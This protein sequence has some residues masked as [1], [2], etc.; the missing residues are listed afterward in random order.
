MKKENI[1]D[2]NR[3]TAMSLWNEQFGKATKVKDFAEREIAKGAYNDRNSK[4]GWNV[5]HILPQS[6]G[7]K[8][9]KSNLI[10]CH[11]LTNDEKADKF[12]CFVAN[13]IKF[14]IVK[15]E[16]HY[17]IQR[18]DSKTKNVISKSSDLNFMDSAVGINYYNQH[19]GMQNK[20]VF[21]G[22][23]KIK[24]TN[25][26]SLALVDFV[27]ELLNDSSINI[28][29]K[30]KSFSEKN[31]DVD[32]S[33]RVFDVPT[34]ED[35]QELLDKCVMIYTYLGF[36]HLTTQSLRSYDMY[37]GLYCFEPNDKWKAYDFE[38]QF[39]VYNRKPNSLIINELVRINTSAKD[40]K[41][42]NASISQRGL[43]SNP[44]NAYYY[45]YYYIKLKENL[46]KGIK[47]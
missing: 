16:N 20:K 38:P 36:Y 33:A 37:Y 21:L 28:N 17:E 7:G 31:F 32:L 40:E 12:P 22:L 47:E 44:E 42:E 41:L 26:V 27:K 5:D 39:T 14:E 46:Q 24:L 34:K 13:G 18:A 8:S 43:L 10:C 2:I 3:E 25:V 11:I 30:V 6:Q 23:I 4:F 15:A 9:V 35:T 45:N 29:V 19:K 1:M